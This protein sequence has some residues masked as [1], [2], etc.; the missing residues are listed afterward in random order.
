M[1]EEIVRFCEKYVTK[2][3]DAVVHTEG[4]DLREQIKYAVEQGVYDALVQARSK[5]LAKDNTEPMPL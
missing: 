1:R 3:Y 5:H 2:A 4:A